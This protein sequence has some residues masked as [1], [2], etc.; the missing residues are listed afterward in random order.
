MN[1]LF[2]AVAN[3]VG[4]GPAKSYP[5][6][7]VTARETLAQVRGGEAMPT[8]IQTSMRQA[9]RES[10]PFIEKFTNAPYFNERVW[11]SG[12]WIARPLPPTKELAQSI[13]DELELSAA[14]KAELADIHSKFTALDNRIIEAG[15]MA[16][17]NLYHRQRAD[18]QARLAAGEEIT[19]GSVR[20][21]DEIE[22]RCEVVRH[23]ARQAQAQ[24][25]ERVYQILR[26]W[27]ERM[28]KYCRELTE[29]QDAQDKKA[30]RFGFAYKP[31]DNLR[32]LIWLSLS[33]YE[34]AISN[35]VEGFGSLRVSDDWFGASMGLN[36][37]AVTPIVDPSVEQAALA[38]ASK[39]DAI[40]RA[41]R[42]QE[43]EIAVTSRQHAAEVER[44]NK[45]NDS[46]REEIEANISKR[47]QHKA[48]AAATGF[49]ASIG[50]FIPKDEPAA[51][52][53]PIVENEPAK[54]TEKKDKEN[55][56]GNKTKN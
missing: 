15:Y 18:V 7:G 6:Q 44:L 46:L 41:Q 17:S 3:I 33:G 39:A 31:S 20:S 26:P 37:P 43:D 27:C 12:R 45:L 22:K 25:S 47:N 23:A 13:L 19:P 8:P 9:P 11:Y 48:E 40:A 54:P 36:L 52:Q 29:R 50:K 30:A 42:R 10:D 28:K 51:S 35:H 56:N 55:G 49:F 16:A 53:L 4:I 21:R 34:A 1:K 2:S 32:S 14:E 5:T 24:L 38:K